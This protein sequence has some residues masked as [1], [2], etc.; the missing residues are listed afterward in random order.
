[1]INND[2]LNVLIKR[3]REATP[4]KKFYSISRIN[5]GIKRH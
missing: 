3:A 1:M 2:Q 5:I 4:K